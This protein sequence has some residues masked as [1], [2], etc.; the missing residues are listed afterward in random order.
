[1]TVDGMDYVGLEMQGE[2]T[3]AWAT[4]RRANGEIGYVGRVV[5]ALERLLPAQSKTMFQL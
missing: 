1:M 2:S 4:R 3:P 5:P